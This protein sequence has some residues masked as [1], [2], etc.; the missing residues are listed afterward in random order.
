MIEVYYK[1]AFNR[2]WEKLIKKLI[3]GDI[4]FDFSYILFYKLHL[5]CKK[6]YKI[7]K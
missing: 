7:S 2:Y 4:V 6:C 1:S 5:K 3:V